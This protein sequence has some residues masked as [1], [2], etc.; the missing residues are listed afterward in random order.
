MSTSWRNRTG[1]LAA[2]GKPDLA[3]SLAMTPRGMRIKSAACAAPTGSAG[4]VGADLRARARSSATLNSDARA[5]ARTRDALKEANGRLSEQGAL[6]Y[7]GIRQSYG[8]GAK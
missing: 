1:P 4:G 7:D 3:V 2:A 5:L 8:E 6:W